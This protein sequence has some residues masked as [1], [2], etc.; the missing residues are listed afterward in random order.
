MKLKLYSALVAFLVIFCST[1]SNEFDLIDD[2]KDI[3]V[4]YGLLNPSDEVHYIRVEKAFLDPTTSALEVAQ[5]ADSLYYAEDEISVKIMDTANGETFSLNRV[6]GT[7]IGFPRND[8]IFLSDPNYLYTFNGDLIEARSYTF[9]LNRGDDLPEVTAQFQTVKE[10]R[11]SGPSVGT[12]L[13]FGRYDR[14]TILRWF[15][16]NGKIF[17]VSAVIHYEESLESDQNTFEDKSIDWPIA[18]N[19]LSDGESQIVF[20]INHES[21]YRFLGENLE[22]KS[23]RRIFRSIDIKVE[24][25]GQELFEFVSVGSANT[26]ITSSQTIPT[27]TNLSEGQGVITSRNDSE[28]QGYTLDAQA[29]DS[30][31]LS[32]YTRDLNFQ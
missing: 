19:I 2:W 8:G 31:Q 20:D 24:S 4:V 10:P 6:N 11:I 27:Y 15:A 22:V 13:K 25:A 1:C 16:E 26:G 30:L 12:P 9:I 28:R 23:V 17:D 32:V 29:R 18:Q 21:F 5:I 7:E 3:P 14:E